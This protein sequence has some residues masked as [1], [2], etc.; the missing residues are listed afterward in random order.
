[1]NR[2]LIGVAIGMILLSFSGARAQ[3]GASSAAAMRARYLADAGYVP[4]A[5]EVAVEEFINYHRHRLPL[6]KAGEAVALDTRWGNNY[7][8]QYQ[9][10]AVLQVGFATSHAN[11]RTDLR[12]L[13]LVL[14]IDKSGSMSAADKMVRVKEALLKMVEQ[15]RPTDRVA[16]VV[17]DSDAVVALSSQALGNKAAYRETIANLWPGS[18][19]NLNAGLMLGYQEAARN[20]QKGATNRVILLTDGIA[21]TGEIDPKKIAGNSMEFNGRGIDL[22]TIGLG[23]EL[24]KDLLRELAKSGH[25]LFHFVA[26]AQDIQKVFVTE[27]QS[28]VAPAARQVKLEVTFDPKLTLSRVFGY[29]PKPGK[30]SV[31]LEL[32]DLNQGL[33]AIA[34][35]KFHLNGNAAKGQVLPVHV[36]FSY[37]DVTKQKPVVV[38]Q[39]A[40]LT[41]GDDRQPALLV[42]TEVRKNY[43]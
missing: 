8:S 14:V 22:S 9:P 4:T 33:T 37:F 6:P 5:N 41:V 36:R 7:L 19:T 2:S 1:M 39:D 34:L 21:N 18:S 3:E 30:N 42:D 15:L 29:E 32:E 20:F 10:D 27:V 26:D 16:I 12:P 43:T 35:M 25:G 40:N 31:S 24:D 11:D 23:L 28:L 13:N 38:N 17:F